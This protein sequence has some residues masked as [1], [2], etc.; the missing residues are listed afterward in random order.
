MG[1]KS[2]CASCFL[3]LIP[4]G[5]VLA[6]DTKQDYFD[7]N[8]SSN[9]RATD[10]AKKKPEE[11][12]PINELQRIYSL[13]VVG[14]YQNDWMQFDS[15]YGAS[16]NI[17]DEGSQPNKDIVEGFSKLILGGKYQP[18]DVLI[19]HNRYSL[20]NS[21][22]ALDLTSNRDTRE[23]FTVIPTIKMHPSAADLIVVSGNYD[24]TT[25][26]ENRDFTSERKG[27]SSSWIRGL[28]KVQSLQI[29]VQQLDSTFEFF[30]SAD[31]QMQ[32]AA[33]QYAVTLRNLSYQARFG[34]NK[35]TRDVENSTF[36][37][38]EYKIISTYTSGANEFQL[39]ISQ[40]ITDS[41]YGGG[42]N[43][44]SVGN[45]NS[46]IKD[47]GS[48]LLDLINERRMEL[49]W[50]T[51]ALCERCSFGLD[52]ASVKRD[53]QKSLQ[54]SIES[55]ASITF[56]YG[57]SRDFS[58]HLNARVSEVELDS[59]SLN[60]N[61]EQAS[62]KMGLSYLITKGLNVEAYLEGYERTSSSLEQNYKENI[63]GLSLSYHF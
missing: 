9:F 16:K 11:V 10:N 12:S 23:I 54:D 48:L 25:Y 33:L 22:D 34:Y 13:G 45:K 63:L 8:L 19:S 42:N 32:I 7:L 61:Y 27:V 53:Y 17:Y 36:S 55:A 38:P 52:L 57:F 30:S 29:I 62:G 60:S 24:K 58:L 35:A 1:Y 50:S 18:L 46:T 6:N 39:E 40:A 21:P 41:S 5:S 37:S 47:A 31:Y 14:Q 3:A 4:F 56:R 44:V 26:Q 28:N 43:A 15:N 51:S 59:S 49:S 2:A 20:L